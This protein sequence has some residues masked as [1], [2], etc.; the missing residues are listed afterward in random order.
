MLLKNYKM[1]LNEQ[2]ILYMWQK[3]ICLEKYHKKISHILFIPAYSF[4]IFQ[5]SHVLCLIIPKIK[6]W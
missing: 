1:K 6:T 3:Y 4:Q 2:Y 5:M